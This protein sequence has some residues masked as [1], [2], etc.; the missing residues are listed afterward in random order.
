MEEW[1]MR[2]EGIEGKDERRVEERMMREEGI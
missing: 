1:M 2:E